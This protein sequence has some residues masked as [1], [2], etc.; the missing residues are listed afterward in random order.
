MYE[1]IN[2]T[3]SNKMKLEWV[4]TTSHIGIARINSR[5]ATSTY[6]LL[7][8]KLLDRWRTLPKEVNYSVLYMKARGPKLEIIS[9]KN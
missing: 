4:Q 9:K 1:I 7:R 3:P 8:E 2:L 5:D 6:H